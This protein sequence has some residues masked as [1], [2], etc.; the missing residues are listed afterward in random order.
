MMNSKRSNK[1]TYIVV[2]VSLFLTTCLFFS[3]EHV[4]AEQETD[5]CANKAQH[6]L[7]Q[8]FRLSITLERV[9]LD[10]EISEE[11]VVETIW[12]VEDLLE[13]YDQWHFVEMKDEELILQRHVDDISPLL[14]TNGYFGITSDGILTIFNGKP[15][16][17][18]VIQSFFQIDVKKL[19]SK[20]HEQLMKGI[21]IKTKADYVDV[22]DAFQHYSTQT[23]SKD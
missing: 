23:K 18:N 10:G 3:K 4:L 12:S 1:V 15:S 20:Q 9:Y 7:A 14:K 6:E 22:L 21:P 11:K 5:S 13:K 2:T 16:D 17:S 8:P 19:E